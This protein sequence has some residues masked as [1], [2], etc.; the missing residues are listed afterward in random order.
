MPLSFKERV[1]M[2]LLGVAA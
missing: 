1:F 2:V